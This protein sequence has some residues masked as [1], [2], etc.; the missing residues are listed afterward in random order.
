MSGQK[1]PLSKLKSSSLTH[2]C[3]LIVNYI[4]G[5]Y[6]QWG[7]KS[8]IVK[9]TAKTEKLGAGSFFIFTVIT[10]SFHDKYIDFNRGS[11]HLVATKSEQGKPCDW[12]KF[13]LLWEPYTLS[14]RT[15][16]H[17]RQDLSWNSQ[18]MRPLILRWG[19]D[20]VFFSS[21]C[22]WLLAGAFAYSCLRKCEWMLTQFFEKYEIWRIRRSW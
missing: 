11:I 13:N 16:C 3:K 14:G 12:F 20:T 17:T 7:E 21:H 9:K 19:G 8:L 6:S 15:L 1:G 5:K 18:S 4:Q 10:R 22:K 2:R